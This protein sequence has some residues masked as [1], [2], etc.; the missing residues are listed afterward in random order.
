MVGIVTY[1]SVSAAPVIQK[2][3][4]SVIAV[5]HHDTCPLRC[6]LFLHFRRCLQLMQRSGSRWPLQ[7]S[8]NMVAATHYTSHVTRHTSLSLSLQRL[9]VLP[10]DFFN[11]LVD[12]GWVLCSMFRAFFVYGADLMFFVSEVYFNCCVLF[13]VSL[14][15]V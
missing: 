15:S 1:E 10:V 8:Q 7:I 9:A 4:R 12:M 6:L 2:H 13:C 3:I 14:M 11:T 5:S